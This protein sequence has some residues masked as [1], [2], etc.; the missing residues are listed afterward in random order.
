MA[1][2]FI[3]G[4]LGATSLVLGALIV[5]VHGLAKRSL[6]LIMGFGAG[7]LLSAVSFELLEE[8]LTVPG[9]RE[10]PSS[11]SSAVPSSST[12]VTPLSPGSEGV[13]GRSHRALQ[14]SWAR[15]STGF[16][17]RRCSA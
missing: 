10:R 7:V 13:A 2:A 1:E 11:V 14:S 3:W 5:F 9:D 12:W 16:P 8:A 6:G 4:L 17:S 15:C